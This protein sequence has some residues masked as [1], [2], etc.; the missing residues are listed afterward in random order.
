M[1][2]RSFVIGTA[3][4]LAAG[5]AIA[6]DAFPSH[7]ITIVNAFPPGGINDIVT[8]PLAS[9]MEMILK[10]PVVVETKAG[11]A[12][13]VGAQV[14]ASAKPDGYTLLSHNTGISGYAEVDKLFGRPV[15]T[16]RSDFIPL[17]RLIA[18]P[19]L[20][21]VNDQQPYK[22]LKEFVEAAKK[23]NTMVFSSGGLYGASHLPLAY[24]EKA[25]G[26]LKLRHLPT[27][28]GGPAITAILGNNAQV[29]TQS[30][31]ATLP[32]IKAG[33]LRPLANFAATRSKRLPDV[34]TLKELGYDVEYYLWVGIFAPKAT[35]A[36][37][38]TTLRSAIDK[39]VHSDAFLAVLN[40]VGQDL[41]YLDGPDFQKF[42]DIDGKRTDEAVISIGKQ[43]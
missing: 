35:P 3:A 10:Q 12:G 36:A 32:H 30:I 42:W 9:S 4:A 7:A 33:K 20:L 19:V 34:P 16:Q 14:A 6:Q 23:E 1:D 27:N 21:L 11:A 15:K 8:R 26:P 31:S 24:L 18:D 40:N 28:G 13:Q 17:A 25:T 2:R 22:T 37:A 29:T 38:V 5:P 43:G 41:A 39:S